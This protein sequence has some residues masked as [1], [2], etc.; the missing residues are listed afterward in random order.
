MFSNQRMQSVPNAASIVRYSSLV[1]LVLLC[2][3]ELRADSPVTVGAKIASAD[4]IAIDQIDHSFWSDLLRKYVDE[5]G[6]VDYRNWKV[7]QADLK[8]LDT[9][10][11][12][13][14]AAQLKGD[15]HREARLAYWINAYNSV[16]VKGILREYPTTSIRNHTAKFFGYNIWHDLQ[17]LVDG[18]SYSLDHI[19]HKIL[20][21]MDE[22]RI[23]FAIVCASISCPRLL[24]EAYTA[25]KLDKQL[26]ENAKVFFANSSNLRADTD[27]KTIYLTK[28]MDWFGEDFGST[29]AKQLKQIA[30]SMPKAIRELAVSAD[31]RV[32]YLNYDWGLNDQSADR[33]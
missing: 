28:I 27:K 31:V 11:A 30:P 19:E 33:E 4:R 29:Q 10:L 13:L 12:Q 1:I 20:R 15:D 5:R 8:L 7:S 24:N 26:S 3:G 21:K 2:Q 32:R 17:L 25:E 14:S 16:T 6:R 18:G 22:P 23:H 9:Y